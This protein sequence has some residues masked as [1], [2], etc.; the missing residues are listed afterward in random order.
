[1]QLPNRD[2]LESSFAVRFTRVNAKLRHQLEDYL[3]YPPDIARVPESFWQEVQDEMNRELA[4]VLLLIWS[5]SA[6]YHG[7]A[8]QDAQGQAAGYATARA[9][10]IAP[11]YAAHS[12][13][14]LADAAHQWRQLSEPIPRGELQQYLVSLFGPRRAERVAMTETTR[15][16]TAGGES[17][18]RSLGGVRDDDRWITREDSRVCPVCRPLHNQPRSVW[19]QQ[20]PSG[21][22]DEVHP[23]CRCYIEYTVDLSLTGRGQV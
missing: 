21:P 22:G 3:G 13:Q 17:A 4:I 11:E 16:Q 2:Q 19:A 14:S 10:Q 18:V 1:M 6:I 20:F 8:A 7:M 15:A 12:R 23:D 5:Q 9:G